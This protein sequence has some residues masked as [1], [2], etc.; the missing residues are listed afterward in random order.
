VFTES[1]EKSL[2][3]GRH[4]HIVSAKLLPVAVAVQADGGLVAEVGGL[5]DELV[6][7]PVP[8]RVTEIHVEVRRHV[9]PAVRVD[10]PRVVH[11][12]VRDRHDAGRLLDAL[13]VA[14][15]DAKRRAEDA[16]R[17]AALVER[18]V[19]GP[20][21]RTVAVGATRHR[22]PAPLVRICRHPAV[23]RIDDE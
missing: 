22:A 8:A 21:E 3:G 6:A 2:F 20:V 13:S 9:L 18:E 19:G 17:D 11:H 15:D 10:D 16:A 14:V 7:F 12:L 4:T 1:P 23:R 5:D